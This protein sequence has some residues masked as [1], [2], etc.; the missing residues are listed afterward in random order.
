MKMYHRQLRERLVAF[1]KALSPPIRYI[2]RNID[3]SPMTIWRFIRG[4]NIREET[5]KRLDQFL[6]H[7]G[8]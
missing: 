4:E 8:F 5:L 3:V 1:R 7:Y 6:K 2:A